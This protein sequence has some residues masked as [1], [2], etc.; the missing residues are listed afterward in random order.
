MK[1]ENVLKTI[2]EQEKQLIKN[3]KNGDQKA[4][5]I[6]FNRYKSH[7]SY[8]IYKKS[9]GDKELVKD[10]TME[11][12]MK[13][14]LKINLYKE[15]EFSFLTWATRIT[16]NHIIDHFKS[17]EI[18]KKKNNIS[19][20]GSNREEYEEDD[21]EIKSEE[22]NSL[23]NFI[24]QERKIIIRNFINK[25]DNKSR[26]VI[27]LRFD[28]ELSYEEISV[29]LNKNVGTIKAMIFRAKEKLKNM[30]NSS[31]LQEKEEIF[32]IV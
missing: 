32:E 16:N 29:T 15:Q 26:N 18:R 2:R 12:F 13:I 20:S 10:L 17:S 21:I 11:I 28:K 31:M 25:L 30:F 9:N 23:D 7:I 19:I 5:K 8:S 22:I 6:L 3:V 1:K 24:K 4:F 14:Y 27:E